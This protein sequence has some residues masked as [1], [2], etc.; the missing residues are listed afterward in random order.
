MADERGNQNNKGI[1]PDSNTP[2]A[3][4]A[5]LAIADREHLSGV[6]FLQTEE[7][8]GDLTVVLQDGT[9]VVIPN[10]LV[11]AQAGLPPTITLADGTVIP[12]QEIL[13]LIPDLNLDEIAPAAGV[14]GP[15][16]PGSGAA[17]S[18]YTNAT[19]G[20]D[21]D[22]G[23]YAGGYG[24]ATGN[25]QEPL[26]E[27]IAATTQETVSAGFAD[28][29][30]AVSI[31]EDSGA[32]AGNLLIGTSSPDGPVSID[33]F[34]I[35]GESGPFVLGSPYTIGGVGTL[36][37]D[38]NGD[39]SFIP[40]PNYNGPVPQVTYTVT[41]GSSTDTSTL[42]ITVNP[43]NDNPVLTVDTSGGVTEDDS[44]PNLTS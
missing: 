20:D 7:H 43:V 16:S 24:Y 21:L 36:Q 33:G 40:E 32:N 31:D 39:Y 13:T 26:D 1:N 27:G 29:N 14:T 5:T 4:G 19:L 25:E 23:S 44:A 34:S 22:H 41:D 8:P 6:K 17:F 42:D 37:V 9:T 35:A 10:Y 2:E 28:A 11:L 15:N 12:G 3:T 38:G 18:T 30:E